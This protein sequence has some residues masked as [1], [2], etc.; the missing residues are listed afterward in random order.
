MDDLG[1][2]TCPEALFSSG[3]LTSLRK[4]TAILDQQIESGELKK[5]GLTLEEQKLYFSFRKGESI[6]RESQAFKDKLKVI[7]EKIEE[8]LKDPE[9][10]ELKRPIDG[11][12]QIEKT[13][14]D[15]L[16][17]IPDFRKRRKMMIKEEKKLEKIMKMSACS[18][19]PL[20][21]PR[22]A[23]SKWDQR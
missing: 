9:L 15:P 21:G 6:Q 10:K 8:Y 3:G 17:E 11:I 4:F 23:N 16:K 1:K 18:Q 12:V 5:A 19:E 20:P 14:F 2:K 13:L 22:L 7:S